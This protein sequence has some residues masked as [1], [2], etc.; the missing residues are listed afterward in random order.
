MPSPLR[1]PWLTHWAEPHDF[2]RLSIMSC[3]EENPDEEK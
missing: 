1:S 3:T 2:E